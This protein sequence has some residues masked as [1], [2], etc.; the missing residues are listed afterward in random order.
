MKNQKS[1]MRIK[2]LILGISILTTLSLTGCGKK[3][4][5]LNNYVS[6]VISGADGYAT[7]RMEI[8]SEGLGEALDGVE[9]A[10]NTTQAEIFASPQ[11][12]L[13]VGLETGAVISKTSQITNGDSVSLTIEMDEKTL[14]ETVNASIL[15]Y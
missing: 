9:F 7:A 4:I 8:D 3:S 15:Y 10:K 14:E 11:E 6:L 1:S 5:D 13:E 12:Y 2:F